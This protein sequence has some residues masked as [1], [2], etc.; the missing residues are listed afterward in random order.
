MKSKGEHI[1][2]P[3]HAKPE[4]RLHAFVRK[5]VTALKFLAG[6]VGFIDSI[7]TIAQFLL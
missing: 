4:T 6:L 5:A 2:E 3:K 1:R 7:I